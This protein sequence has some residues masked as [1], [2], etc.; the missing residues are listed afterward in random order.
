[1]GPVRLTV[2]LAS[3]LLAKLI[4]RSLEPERG[5]EMVPEALL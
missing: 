2:P 4:S 1:L 5:P 3:V